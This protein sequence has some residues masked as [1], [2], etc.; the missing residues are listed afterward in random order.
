MPP[1]DCPCFPDDKDYLDGRSEISIPY[2]EFEAHWDLDIL[3]VDGIKPNR[4]ISVRDPFQV[5]LRIELCGRMWH[6]MRGT[7]CWD[8]RF[9]PVG[10]G[11]AVNLSSA[12][13]GQFEFEWDGCATRCIE[14]YVTVP[15][16]TI[17]GGVPDSCCGALYIVGGVYGFHCCG[18]VTPVSGYE[19]K[20]DFEFYDPGP[21]GP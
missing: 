19:K 21:G 1:N 9:T 3:D 11:T 12:L 14:K 15:A 4:I 10:V 16:G 7:W 17:P 5:R 2:E 20:G 8:V 6:C 13:P 18:G